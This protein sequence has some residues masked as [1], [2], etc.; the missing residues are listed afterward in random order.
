MIPM[1]DVEDLD[2]DEGNRDGDKVVEPYVFQPF[3]LDNVLRASV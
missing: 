1:K 3:T 2:S